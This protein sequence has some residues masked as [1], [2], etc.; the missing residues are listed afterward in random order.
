MTAQDDDRLVTVC[1]VCLTAACWQGEFY[2]EAAKVANTT[3]RT[4]RELR[5]L[6]REHEH[7]WRADERD[8]R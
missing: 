1:A 4:V 7:Y 2:C 6:G 8:G 3:T 5:A